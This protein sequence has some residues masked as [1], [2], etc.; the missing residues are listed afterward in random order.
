MKK[1]TTTPEVYNHKRLNRHVKEMDKFLY[2]YNF[3]RLN[4]EKHK[5]LSDQL[6]VM[7]LKQQYKLPTTLPTTTTNRNT[8]GKDQWEIL[9]VGREG[10][11]RGLND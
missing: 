11:D 1:M 7:K 6:L 9:K 4:Q 2:M 5:I 10:D 3:P 8:E